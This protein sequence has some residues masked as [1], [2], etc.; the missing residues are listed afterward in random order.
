VAIEPAA[1]DALIET[2]R[3][4]GFDIVLGDADFPSRARVIPFIHRGS[5][6]PLDVVLAGPAWRGSSFGARFLSTSKGKGIPVI[7]PEDLMQ[8]RLWP[9]VPKTS[10]TS[11][12]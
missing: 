3:R 2:M 12:L 11:A 6:I 9:G 4:H 10:R 7:S 1:I 5:G 8:R